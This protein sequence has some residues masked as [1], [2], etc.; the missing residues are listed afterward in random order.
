M[1][2]A[3]NDFIV[4]DAINQDL[5]HITPTQW[6]LLAHRH[7]GIGADQI[8]LIEKAQAGAD[9]RYRIF[10]ADG[11][12]V[13]QCGNGSR[14]FARYVREQGLTNKKA[15]RVEV[16]A[17]VITL[18]VHADEQISVDMGPPIFT[19]AK[20]PFIDDQLPTQTVGD[21]TLYE[22]STGT[23]SPLVTP[24]QRRWFSVLSMGNPHAVQ[25]VSNIDHAPIPDEA[26]QW[27]QHSA[28][29][30][31]VNVGY[32]QILD[33]HHI[34]LRVFER[35]AGETLSCG[36]GACAAVVAGIRRALLDSPVQVNTRGGQLEI[37]WDGHTV[38]MTGPAQTVF[39]GEIDLAHVT[40]SELT[41]PFAT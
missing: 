23:Q 20:I 4:L 40:T 3:G 22:L 29:P 38:T 34:C 32:M 27:Q 13:E 24:I 36:T 21:D 19:A 11:G 16:G 33:R 8:L 31:Q 35:G 5:T 14:C 26:A 15:I 39:T 28:F 7:F 2:G 10:N 9:F 30:K 6:R 17:R 41:F 18:H 25:I 12:E 1:H 37:A